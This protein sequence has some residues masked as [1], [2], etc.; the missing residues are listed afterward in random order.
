MAVQKEQCDH[1]KKNFET[2]RCDLVIWLGEDRLLELCV[3]CEKALEA[4]ILR[5]IFETATKWYLKD[6]FKKSDLKG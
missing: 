2:T 4:D 3:A 1:L 6:L 5:S